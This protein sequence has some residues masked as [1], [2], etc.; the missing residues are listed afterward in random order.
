MTSQQL[1]IPWTGDCVATTVQAEVTNNSVMNCVLTVNQ[2][3]HRRVMQHL[4]TRNYDDS[5]Q[6]SILAMAFK[7]FVAHSL[8]AP[9]VFVRTP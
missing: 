1:R 3:F 2:K 9:L 7:Q 5:L 6:F 8:L 4:F